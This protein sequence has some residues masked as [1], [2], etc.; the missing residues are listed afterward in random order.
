MEAALAASEG[1]VQ[2]IAAAAA[3]ADADAA[4]EGGS[5]ATLALA[6]PRGLTTAACSEFCKASLR[7]V[8]ARVFLLPLASRL[9]R[10][11]LQCLSRF[12][13]WLQALLDAAAAA[14]D[15]GGGRG[16]AALARGAPP[17]TAAD[18]TVSNDASSGAAAAAAAPSAAATAATPA[19]AL[20]EADGAATLYLD[21]LAVVAWLRDEVRPRLPSLLHLPASSEALIAECTAALAEGTDALP[22]ASPPCAHSWSAASQARARRGLRPSRRSPPHIG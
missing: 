13:Q 5:L 19:R 7:C 16:G 17:P 22:A 9:F 1:A 15:G 12:T 8:N 11:L 14:S 20:L 10:L 2:Q 3:D 6:P 4:P 18:A 21:L